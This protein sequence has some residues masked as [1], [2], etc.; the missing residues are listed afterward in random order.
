MFGPPSRAT[1]VEVSS[2][3]EHQHHE[4]DDEQSS[5]VH[6][7]LPDGSRVIRHSTSVCGEHRR[8][9]VRLRTVRLRTPV[10]RPIRHDYPCATMSTAV[11]RLRP[12]GGE[13]ER[14]RGQHLEIRE[15]LVV[16]RRRRAGRRRSVLGPGRPRA[17]RARHPAHVRPGAAGHLA[18]TMGRSGP[19]RAGRRHA[20]VRGAR[21]RRLGS[22]P[23]DGLSG[24]RPPRLSRQHSNEDC[25][26]T[27]C[28]QGKRGREAAG[29]AG[30][31]PKGPRNGGPERN[32]LAASCGDV[33]PGDGIF[34]LRVARASSSGR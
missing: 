4:D 33:Q 10:R 31:D 3:A 29:N 9:S 16:V 28:G 27:P 32:R 23:A 7:L 19:G 5:R 2:A 15:A 21:S 13:T 18:S 17:V 30:R 22:D 34:G 20:G 24:R 12:R 11:Q 14:D 8:A 6:F 1:S 25:R 26:R